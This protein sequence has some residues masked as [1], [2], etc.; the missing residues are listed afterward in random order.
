MVGGAGPPE[1]VLRVG[2]ALAGGTAREAV[3]SALVLAG[4][5]WPGPG[6]VAVDGL[7]EPVLQRPAAACRPAGRVPGRPQAGQHWWAGPAP[8]ARPACG[9]WGPRPRGGSVVEVPSPAAARA[10]MVAE[11]VK[12]LGGSGGLVVMRN[13]GVPGGEAGWTLA[14]GRGRVPRRREPSEA[15]PRRPVGLRASTATR[16]LLLRLPAPRR[17][18]APA[19]G[20]PGEAARGRRAAR[21]RA[22]PA[23]VRGVE[24]GEN[25]AGLSDAT[26]GHRGRVGTGRRGLARPE[27]WVAAARGPRTVVVRRPAP[28]PI[29]RRSG[30][31][32]PGARARVCGLRGAR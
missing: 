25:A 6:V 30:P 10:G 22:M 7:P 8:W 5:A 26:G 27:G 1:L 17:R 13:W 23:G 28:T 16:R 3:P 32:I 31:R 29:G 18:V 20:R 14:V 15:Q 4:L 21:P 9:R 24:Q 2:A 19:A 12:W 11:R